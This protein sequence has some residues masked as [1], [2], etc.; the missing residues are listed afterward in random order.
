[1]SSLVSVGLVGLCLLLAYPADAQ[2]R[3][4]L[5]GETPAL[6]GKCFGPAPAGRPD[7]E[8]APSGQPAPGFSCVATCRAGDK[9][10]AA[11]AQ[12]IT[13]IGR[14]RQDTATAQLQTRLSDAGYYY[15]TQ[16]QSGR[17]GSPET[18][19]QQWAQTFQPLH[20]DEVPLYAFAARTAR[21]MVCP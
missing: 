18:V 13:D 15:C 11:L 19:A 17:A 5:P 12:K 6:Y 1:M 21:Q 4:C 14:C 3:P 7:R 10:C 2:E 16:K 9:F 8:G 20:P